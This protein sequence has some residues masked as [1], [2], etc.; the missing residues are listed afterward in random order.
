[1]DVVVKHKTRFVAKRYSPVVGIDFSETYAFLVKFTTITT[2]VAI[3][4]TMD[5]K[6]FHI[7]C[8]MASLTGELPKDIYMDPPPGFVTISAR[9]SCFGSSNNSFL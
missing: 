5:L 7:E 6:I 4:T 1:M 2:I 3:G 9:I 8:T